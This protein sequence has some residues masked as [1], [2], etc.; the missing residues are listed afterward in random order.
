VRL[1]G[2]CNGAIVA[3]EMARELTRTGVRVECVVLVDAVLADRDRL[4]LARR[5]AGAVRHVLEVTQLRPALHRRRIAPL[6]NATWLDAHERVLG[7]WRSLLTRYRPQPYAGRIVLLWS[8]DR[9]A[10]AVRQTHL[11]R[12]F[13]P[14][15]GTGRVPGAH[16]SAITRHLAQTS[17]I[18]VHHLRSE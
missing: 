15:A 12:R 18:V 6:A 17:R 2:F 14:D 11:W 5:F 13:A 9:A 3:Y 16:L 8:D 7:R 10:D 4:P 1:A